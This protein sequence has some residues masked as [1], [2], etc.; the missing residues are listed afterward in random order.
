MLMITNKTYKTYKFKTVMS[1][2][3]VDIRIL[4]KSL[5]RQFE[6]I[7]TDKVISNSYNAQWQLM[8][9]YNDLTMLSNEIDNILNDCQSIPLSN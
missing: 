2:L 3:Y 1:N 8:G 7:A 4:E 5:K 6:H 9:L